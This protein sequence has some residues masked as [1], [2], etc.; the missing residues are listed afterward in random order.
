MLR[1]AY[2]SKISVEVQ[3]EIAVFMSQNIGSS[4]ITEYGCTNHMYFT[5][6]SG[7][8]VYFFHSKAAVY[9]KINQRMTSGQIKDTGFLSIRHY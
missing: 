4:K 9:L 3:R 5:S 8:N 2:L 1:I 7:N 6:Y